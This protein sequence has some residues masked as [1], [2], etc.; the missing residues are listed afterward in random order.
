MYL[1]FTGIGYSEKDC[2]VRIND[3]PAGNI[4]RA[5]EDNVVVQF[6]TFDGGY[7]T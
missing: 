5:D 3:I 4:F 1:C 2:V 7:E 6:Q